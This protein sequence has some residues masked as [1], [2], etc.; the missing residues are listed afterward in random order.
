MAYASQRARNS[1]QWKKV[2]KRIIARDQGICAY[3][4]QENSTTVDHVLPVVRGGDDSESNLV[5]ACVSCNTSKGKKM[6]F[7]FFE[8]VS[9]T[10][11]IQGVFV[12]EN[13]SLSHD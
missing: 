1:S 9:T 10:K 3:C 8:A 12:P 5:C 13:V 6:P 7:D 4:G 11:H 2:R